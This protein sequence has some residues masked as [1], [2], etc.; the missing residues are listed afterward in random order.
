MDFWP[1]RRPSFGNWLQVSWGSNGAI[2]SSNEASNAFGAS[3]IMCARLRGKKEPN[4]KSTMT[5]K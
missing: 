2:K 5:K 4:P 1:G 3:T